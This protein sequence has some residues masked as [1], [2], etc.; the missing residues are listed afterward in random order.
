[1]ECAETA[2]LSNKEYLKRFNKKT[3]QLRIPLVGS[4]DL[5]HRCNLR[6]V[7]CYLSGYTGHRL[8]KEMETKQVLSVIDEI[9]EAGCLYFLITG[10]EPLLRADFPTIYRHAKVKG[11]IVSVFTNGT[12]ITDEILELFTDLPPNT[13]EISLYGATAATYENIT[14]VPG[15]YKKCIN[16]TQRL[17]DCKTHLRLKTIL[18][19]LNRNEFFDIENMA[20]EYGVPFRFDPAIFPCINGD[21]T[22]LTL[23][24]SPEDAVEKEFSDT[25]RAEQRVKYFKRTQGLMLSDNLYQC[26]AGVTSF[27]IDPYGSLQPC[28][29]I[30]NVSYDLSIGSFMEGWNDVIPQI[31]NLKAGNVYECNT[32][33][34]RNLCDFC[35]A[36]FALENGA[37][38]IRSEYLCAIGNLRFQMMQKYL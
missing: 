36:F 28:L 2:W 29:M 21:N 17:L 12:L 34:K 35:P 30:R 38:D 37:D 4:L 27:H 19:D 32:C 15:S 3:A 14:R 8:Q 25:K 13:I 22:P 18:M 6:C 11:L 31:R 33:E 7:H 23:R 9:T 1:M 24:V 5:T 20:K 26:G 16:G 10:G